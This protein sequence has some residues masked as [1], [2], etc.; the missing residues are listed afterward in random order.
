VIVHHQYSILSTGDLVKLH[1]DGGA[2]KRYSRYIVP[3][4]PYIDSIC[5]SFMASVFF[6]V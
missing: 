5:K 1:H 2:N 4:I 3:Y 6:S